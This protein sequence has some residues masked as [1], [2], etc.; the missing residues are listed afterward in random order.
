[1]TA[2][3]ML[4]PI[5][6][7]E[8]STGRFPKGSSGNPAGRPRG[9]K[10][11]LSLLRERI[12]EDDASDVLQIVRQ[13]ALDGDKK[14]VMFLA[15]NLWQ[16]PKGRLIEL[17]LP[18]IR[19]Q[20]DVA[21]ASDRI[22]KAVTSGQITLEE[23]KELD[24]FV[25]RRP[26]NLRPTVQYCAPSQSE[27]P[28]EHGEPAEPSAD[29]I[30]FAT[31]DDDE[32]EGPIAWPAENQVPPITKA[33]PYSG[34]ALNTSRQEGGG[35]VRSGVTRMDQDE[36]IIN[37]EDRRRPVEALAG[38]IQDLARSAEQDVRPISVD[39]A[40][41]EKKA[42]PESPEVK[43]E[44]AETPND[45]RCRERDPLSL[46]KEKRLEELKM[47]GTPLRMYGVHPN[48]NIGFPYVEMYSYGEN[49]QPSEISVCD[50]LVRQYDEAPDPGL[51]EEVARALFT[52]GITLRKLKRR[53]E[54]VGVFD[55]LVGR[56]GEAPELV[57]QEGVAWARLNKGITLR[58]MKRCEE[59]I[60]LFDE[61][62]RQLDEST[63]PALREVVA[64]ALFNKGVAFGAMRPHEEAIVVYDELMGRFDGAPEPAL[65]E[66]VAWAML[67][68]GAALNAMNRSEEQ[69]GVDDEVIRRFGESPEQGLRDAVTAA[70]FRQGHYDAINNRVKHA[71]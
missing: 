53:E 38:R 28:E 37:V 60:C 52:K 4:E 34:H 33:A 48:P 1:M 45:S 61:L 11:K 17:D 46:A 21:I 9:T 50:D 62:V 14:A 24:E 64:K 7:R 8:P 55:E 59:A 22:F 15:E 49:A 58:T 19:T 67:N 70:K 66:G 10:N 27:D 42:E 18:K 51:R 57:L 71:A 40:D 32:D 26:R 43:A 30:P 41:L 31:Q 23:G 29:F 20:R 69:K 54:A 68:K 65:Q 6:Q 5:P 12:S 47:S 13:M 36:R 16:R 35:N 44:P 3:P 56:F 25:S 39:A 63:E 2:R